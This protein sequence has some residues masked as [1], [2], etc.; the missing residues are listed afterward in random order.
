MPFLF[1]VRNCSPEVINMQR[2]EA[3]LNI[4]LPRLDN[5]DIK[6][7][8]AWNICFVIYRQHQSKS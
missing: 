6:Q 1:N 5:F 7:K 2:R 8:L 3:E 4:I